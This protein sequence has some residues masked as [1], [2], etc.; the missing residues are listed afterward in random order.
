VVSHL[1]KPFRCNG[2]TERP[3]PCADRRAALATA[4]VHDQADADRALARSGS[5]PVSPKGFDAETTMLVETT[6]RAR[7]R[8]PNAPNAWASPA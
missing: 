1:R 7:T 8:G 6:P 4:A 2:D 3:E 5:V